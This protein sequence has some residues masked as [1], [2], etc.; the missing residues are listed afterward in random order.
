MDSYVLEVLFLEM[1]KNSIQDKKKS[2]FKKKK[3][4]RLQ[5]SLDSA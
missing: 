3:K 5:R 1:S 4:K 2:H